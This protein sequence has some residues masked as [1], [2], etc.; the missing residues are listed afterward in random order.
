MV[1]VKWVLIGWCEL[2]WHVCSVFSGPPTGGGNS[3]DSLA[4]ES[5][6]KP[7]P[8]RSPRHSQRPGHPMPPQPL[9]HTPP[10]HGS[11]AA[12]L[13]QNPTSPASQQPSPSAQQAGSKVSTLAASHQAITSLLSSG[14]SG[15]WQGHHQ[16]HR[17][18]S[19]LYVIFVA[20]IAIS[21]R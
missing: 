19:G 20:T 18:S 14:P 13:S 11:P 16:G 1:S 3:N 17:T 8:P 5:N 6:L 9:R 21:I 7:S 4:S 2:P 12:S 15:E 10:Q